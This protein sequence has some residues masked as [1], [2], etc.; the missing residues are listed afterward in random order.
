VS[1]LD[2]GAGIVVFSENGQRLAGG[3]KMGQAFRWRHQIAYAATG[4]DGE[5][6]LAVV[7]TPHIGG[8]VEYYQY[9][10]GG[11]SIVAEYPGITSHTLGSRNLDLAAAGDFDG[12]GAV[13]LLLPT[14]DL[15]E[16]VAIRRSSTGAEQV[17]RLPIAGVMSTNLAGVTFPNGKL[18]IAVGRTD[19]VLNLWLPP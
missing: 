13:E 3:P 14:P 18:A 9:I 15:T 2:L 17:W 4:P 1:D 12:D 8:V 5:N 6:E 11:L 7:R 19:G 10:D 16:L